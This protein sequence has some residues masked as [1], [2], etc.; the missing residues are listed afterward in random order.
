MREQILGCRYSKAGYLS[1]G[2]RTPLGNTSSSWHVACSSGLFQFSQGIRRLRCALMF[3]TLLKTHRHYW[4][5]RAFSQAKFHKI[6]VPVEKE[7]GEG[8]YVYSVLGCCNWN[9]EVESI[10]SKETLEVRKFTAELKKIRNHPKRKRR[11]ESNAYFLFVER[12]KNSL[13]RLSFP[14]KSKEYFT[15]LIPISIRKVINAAL[16]SIFIISIENNNRVSCHE[17]VNWW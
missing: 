14:G 3:C 2:L 13:L 5:I 4:D 9:C 7:K 17:I 10:Y 11:R 8:K 16:T 12:N 6:L 1:F 15:I